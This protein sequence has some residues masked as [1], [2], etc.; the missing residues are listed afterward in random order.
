VKCGAD[1][2]RP[3]DSEVLVVPRQ[4]RQTSREHSGTR[5]RGCFFIQNAVDDPPGWPVERS[6]NE[7]KET[8]AAL[9]AA[10]KDEARA[11]RCHPYRLRSK[12]KYPI[13]KSRRVP[14]PNKNTTFA[15]AIDLASTEDILH[16]VPARVGRNRW[17]LTC[18]SFRRPC[19]PGMCGAP[20]SWATI[21]ARLPTPSF[22]KMR[23]R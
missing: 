16:D 12:K 6:N 19:A 5:G 17:L 20:N 15:A 22:A 10:F 4:R 1:R 11:A 14:P 8:A 9:G 18:Q 7:K 2:R 21:S 23:L 13:A 3:S